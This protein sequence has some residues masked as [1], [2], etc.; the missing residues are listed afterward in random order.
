MLTLSPVVK[1]P[2]SLFWITDPPIP[3]MAGGSD[4]VV[5]QVIGS[6]ISDR[7]RYVQREQRASRAKLQSGRCS[8]RLWPFSTERWVRRR[9]AMARREPLTNLYLVDVELC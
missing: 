7:R 8:A 5:G 1:R 6:G 9:Q 3:R 4:V 2:T